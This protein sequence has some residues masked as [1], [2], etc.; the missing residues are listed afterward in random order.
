MVKN[1]DKFSFFQKKAVLL[2]KFATMTSEQAQLLVDLDKKVRR[3][4]ALYESEKAG[5]QTLKESLKQKQN[6]LM[7]AHKNLVDL[8]NKFDHL[9]TARILN[10]TEEES[11]KSGK[12]L[13]KLVREID[14]CIA[15]LN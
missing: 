11:Q 13:S 12:K 10:L 7:L 5:N 2:W 1:R 9:R 8:Q 3:L 4:L 14:K 15:L 6:E